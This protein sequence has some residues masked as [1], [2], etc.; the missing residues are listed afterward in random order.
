M[1][2]PQKIRVVRPISGSSLKVGQT[3]LVFRREQGRG[4]KA[5]AFFHQRRPQYGHH[6][7][8]WRVTL[9]LL[10]GALKVVA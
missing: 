9:G 7:R 1:S 2:A 4:L 10:T 6:V 5:D 8:D 3:Y